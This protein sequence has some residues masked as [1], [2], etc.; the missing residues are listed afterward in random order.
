MSSVTAGNGTRLLVLPG[1]IHSEQFSE[2]PWVHGVVIWG[3]N[4]ATHRERFVIGSRITMHSE[5]SPYFPKYS[6]NP[7]GK[8]QNK[9]MTFISIWGNNALVSLEWCIHEATTAV[10]IIRPN[11]GDVMA[12]TA[13][14]I[15]RNAYALVLTGCGLPAQTADEHFP[16]RQTERQGHF[17]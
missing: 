12:L 10:R 9:I 16:G 2:R 5:I 4:S 6:R 17:V 3:L 7:S 1:H 8:R 13:I 11:K 14:N 15:W